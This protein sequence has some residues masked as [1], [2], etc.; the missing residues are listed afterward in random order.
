MKIHTPSIE[1]A[2]TA[3]QAH[4]KGFSPEIAMVLGSGMGVIAAEVPD[5]I[6]IEYSL[7]PGF[8]QSTVKGH[9][10]RLVMGTLEGKKVVIMQGRTHF[11]EGHP[12]QSLGFPVRVLNR[13]GANTL[14][15]T[16][17]A[18]T[19]NQNFNVGDIMLITDHLNFTFKNPLTGPNNE[20][21]GPRFPDNSAT[22]TPALR[23]IAKQ[24][25]A[26]SDVLLRE[27][28]YQF[29]IGPSYE[30]PAEVQVA[31][32]LGSDAVGMSTFPEAITA[33][34][35]GMN[36]LGFSLITNFAAGLTA[37]K[38][39]HQEVVDVANAQRAKFTRLLKGVLAK[40]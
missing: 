38:Q 6:E 33:N 11:Y 26:E 27:G 30:T 10:G 22:Y 17:A 4:A 18:G 40:I 7:I 34:H 14:I 13:L 23:E 12:I 16:N 21:I 3:I 31:Q 37:E 39:N 36:V 29:N 25:A 15:L 2:L 19:V 24:A 5:P 35:A 1:D 28:V 9:A 32:F 8:P 20:D